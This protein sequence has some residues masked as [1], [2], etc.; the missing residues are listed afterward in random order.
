MSITSAREERKFESVALVLLAMGLAI[1][2]GVDFVRIEGDIGRMNTLFKYYLEIWVLFSVAS[3]YM[4][5]RILS[6][7]S[8][9]QGSA[10]TD[11]TLDS[12]RWVWPRTAWNAVL[13]LL[14]ACSLIYTVMG[15]KDRL[16][17]RFNDAP[18]TLDGAA[19]MENAVHFERDQR[20]ELGRDLE[21]IRWLQDNVEGS[22]V[23][24]EA[25]SVQYRWGARIATYTGLPTVLGWPWHQM[26]QRFAYRGEI[27]RRA[28]DVAE[29]YN[30]NGITRAEELL[31]RY[32][33]AYV[34]VGELERIYYSEAGLS[35]FS[36][37]AE[38]GLLRRVYSNRGVVIYRTTWQ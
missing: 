24:L 14:I 23:I 38:Q 33:V 25:H 15:T 6:D 5:W 19:F 10:T 4:V 27:P 26:Q 11:R 30:T 17:D 34:V 2:A 28:T 31:R 21:A 1:G 18:L 3:A 7:R 13:V 12:G 32:D 8:L 29:I 16:A 36:Q 37:M 20:L 35:K 22:P 9:A